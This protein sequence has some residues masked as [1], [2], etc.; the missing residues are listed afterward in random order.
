MVRPIVLVFQEF[1][2]QTVT[3]TTPDLNC[4]IIGPAY[5]IQDYLDDKANLEVSNYGVLDDPNPYVP[6]PAFTPAI[7]LA[8]PPAI[9]A[10]AWVDP[11]SVNVY[12]DDL[13][14]IMASGADG[15]TTL[16]A[17]NEN[18]LVSASATFL[19]D[20]VRSGDTL[21]IDNPDGLGG[22]LVRTVI[23]VDSET[24]LRVTTNFINA[25][26]SL[27]Y[28]LERRLDDQLIDSSFV[29]PPV[30]R[31]SNEIQILGGVT[32]L[33]NAVA[34]VVSYARVFVE[35]RAYRM[36]LQTLD[37]VETTAEIISKIGKIDA[38]NPLAAACFVAL[39]NA[40]QAP[41]QFYGVASDDLVGYNL[42]KDVLSTDSSIYAIVPLNS[43]IAIIASFKAD[44]ESLA[45]PTVALSTGVPQKFRV[46]IGSGELPL[47]DTL[48]EE[49][50]TGT[51]E[52]L[53]GA[54]P[55]GLKSI[56][57]TGLGAMATN[58]LRPGDKLVLSASENAAP[59]DGTYT[60]AHIN[61][62]TNVELNEV[63]PVAV[64]AAE[65]LNYEVTRPSTGGTIIPL[66]D[67][68]A[69]RN[70]VDGGAVAVLRVYSKVA[71]ITPGARTIALVDTNDATAGVNSIVEVAG[72]STIVNCDIT[73]GVT[74]ATIAAALNTGAGV[75]L[76][77]S[78]SINVVAEALV[79]LGAPVALGATA[80]SSGTPGVDALASAG[81]L[82]AV[83]VRFFDSSK[84]FLTDGVLPGDF[85]E[86]PTD[87]TGV[88]TTAFKRFAV[89][90]VIS[91][92]RLEI[93]NIASGV[94]R[95]NTST[96]E[97]ELPHTDN[98][99]GT[100]TPVTQGSIRYRVVRDLTKTQQVTV[101]AT[102]AQSLNSRRAILA[103]PDSITVAGLVDGSKPRNPDG[104][105]ADADP[106][107]GFFM[108]AVIGGMTAGLPSHQGFS[109]L[110]CAGISRVQ[111]S[112]DYF[113]ESQ[114]TDLSDS[115]WYVFVQDSPVSLPYSIHQLTTDPATLESG[116]YSIVKNFD[117]VSIFY[118][119][120]LEPFLG[121]WNINNDTL[122]FIRQALNT[123]TD[124]L[125]LR[126]V[127]R[128]GAPI[129]NA[130]ITSI[131]VSTAS[132]D[133]VEV[134]MQVDLP[135]PLNVIGLHLIA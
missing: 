63:L 85:I 87:P 43:D 49:A 91:E 9:E 134:F 106:Q 36:D 24:Q 71:G 12:F 17:P 10:G 28:R 97:Y 109:R 107:P 53:S 19:T 93:V 60:I 118:A 103:W 59:L 48:V 80:L 90:A 18:T 58:N 133:R 44:N 57:I 110:G 82:D 33:V 5:Q 65:G 92:Q 76:S 41:V 35:Y 13:R 21:I 102:Q 68:R 37:T 104:S 78:G 100:G 113:S 128:I 94:Y 129:N 50:V 20:G 117:F 40:G 46:V 83:F 114:L 96:V 69:R 120:I 112:S 127:A 29:V 99:L 121:V 2:Q 89:N 39:Q 38:R 101:L 74:A 55:P 72:V 4:L 131:E 88:F 8:A 108:A 105:L 25:L 14:V 32:V 126:R 73:G 23:G 116:E 86:I 1:A 52:A 84:T 67:N 119:N 81:A 26:G 124:N 64:V 42:A 6:P 111:D 66:V 3:P 45:N 98:R 16:T 47:T 54:V 7:T 79:A 11:D 75:V 15:V 132:A 70:L 77:F 125:K 34:R 115:G 30:F 56:T 130:T 95:N 123:G 61:S 27:N 22:T 51:T 31:S 62:Q 122:G 135:K